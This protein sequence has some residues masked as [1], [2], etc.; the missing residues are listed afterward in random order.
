M[1]RDDRQDEP[2]S[3]PGH[4]TP[5]GY[6]EEKPAASELGELGTPGAGMTA[7]VPHA[8]D[9]EAVEHGETPAGDLHGTIVTTDS[10]ASV[11]HHDATT[12]MDAHTAISDDDHGHAE[13]RLGPIDWGAWGYAIV[14]GLA[15]LVVV[16][17]FFLAST[18][19]A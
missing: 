6:T 12:H 16:A 10:A 11:A 9:A 8:A 17:L 14:G 4:A 7:D 3:E 1:S 2:R 18:R 13:P 5:E 15:G 19:P